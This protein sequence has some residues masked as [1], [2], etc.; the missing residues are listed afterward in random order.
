M[1]IERHFKPKARAI[2]GLMNSTDNKSLP[3]II[4]HRGSSAHAPENTLPAFH[5]ALEQGADGIELDVMLS[6][7]Q[8][9]I[10]IHD[11][12]LERTTNGQGKV[13]NHTAAEL[14]ELDAGA[15]FS[16]AYN[17][18]PL[19]LLDEVYEQLGGKFLINVEL[20]NYHSPRDPLPEI[21]LKLTQKHNLL[22]KVIF[23]SFNA[24][25]LTRLKK[26]EPK[27]KTGLLCLP[28]LMGTLYRGAFGRLFNYD[29]LHPYHKDTTPGM[30]QAAH[31]R[32]KEVN[33]WT[34][35]ETHHILRMKSVGVDS[36]ITD[37][38]LYTRQVLG[39]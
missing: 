17:N 24:R 36:I 13:P 2:I 20:K 11:S 22:E 16:E 25:N 29:A 38:P 32:G 18:T 7:D 31:K 35:D 3:L 14:R 37:D 1:A 5:L 33:V 30:V 19:P 39:F 21:A 9:L 23:S 27:A 12:T 34:V 28:G 10:V 15:W 8:K 26:L 6:K 4:G